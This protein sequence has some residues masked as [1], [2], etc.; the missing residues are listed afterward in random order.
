MLGRGLK[1]FQ[2]LLDSIMVGKVDQQAL[3]A[4]NEVVAECDELI[5]PAEPPR[6]DAGDLDA[7]SGRHLTPLQNL[8][9]NV[10]ANLFARVAKLPDGAAA[11]AA[12]LASLVQHAEDAKRE[13]W[14]LVRAAPPADI[15]SLQ[16]IL[17]DLE[18][19][20][21]EAAA[22]RV[23]PLQRWRP[24]DRKPK[25]AFDLVARGSRRAFLK[26]IEARSAA[27]LAV[28]LRELPGASLVRPMLADGVVWRTRFAATFP[29]ASIPDFKRWVAEA[30]AIGE[31]L[32]R[33]T[34]EGEDLILVPLLNGRAAIDHA[35]QLSRADDN[36][37]F[38]A[39]LRSAGQTSLLAAPET[40]VVSRL[41]AAMVAIPP[42]L[43]EFLGAARDLH[44]LITLRLACPERPKIEQQC[45]DQALAD[46]NRSGRCLLQLFDG[47][48]HS[49]ARAMRSYIEGVLAS[50]ETGE[51]PS[52]P[53]QDAVQDAVLELVWRQSRDQR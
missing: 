3:A 27:L 49:A 23:S 19:V 34:E 1:A 39:F 36:S 33:E 5:A 12:H 24:A 35:Y 31:R 37:M 51:P 38:G 48:D 20:A 46:M 42:E 8:L 44:G 30:Q 16:Q 45:L 17:R 11:L 2:R 40:C 41:D 25:G 13:P 9:W 52:A 29:L 47:I 50:L 14:S 4:L 7:P 26:R 6:S 10:N 28:V 43:G 21:L 32:R 18:V 15:D 53:S 22:S